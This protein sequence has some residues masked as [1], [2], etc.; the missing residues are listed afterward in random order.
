MVGY[1]AMAEAWDHP[2][3]IRLLMRTGWD[4]LRIANEFQC[5][6]SEIWNCLARTDHPKATVIP[7]VQEVHPM[8]DSKRRYVSRRVGQEVSDTDSLSE[9]WHKIKV[10][11]D[12]S[13]TD[14]VDVYG[15]NCWAKHEHNI[16]PDGIV[17]L[18]GAVNPY[19]HA[20]P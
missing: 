1:L 19:V 10:M 11:I 8:S 6:E 20:S 2:E 3:G 7:F 14:L 5:S 13:T 17:F 4:T 15:P 9:Y 18:R 12:G 16:Q